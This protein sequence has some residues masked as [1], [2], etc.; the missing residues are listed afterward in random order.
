M[1]GYAAPDSAIN[2][3][4]GIIQRIMAIMAIRDCPLDIQK[5]W[6]AA[7]EVGFSDFIYLEAAHVLMA[8]QPG[9]S[10]EDDRVVISWDM[11]KLQDRHP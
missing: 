3:R 8:E 7:E 9:A 5:L 2:G 10:F 1:A 6:R 11:W 4:G